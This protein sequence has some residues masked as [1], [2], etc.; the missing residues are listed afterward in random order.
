MDDLKQE[1]ETA[2]RQLAGL[3]DPEEVADCSARL[4]SLKNALSPK[5]ASKPKK[6]KQGVE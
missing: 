1:I 4:A 6:K 5:P 2:E 3:S